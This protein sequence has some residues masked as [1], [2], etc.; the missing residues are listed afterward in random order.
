MGSSAFISTPSMVNAPSH[1]GKRE[2][3]KNLPFLDNL[4]VI[5]PPHFGHLK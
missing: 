2:Q 5:S 1:S 4:T 3:D